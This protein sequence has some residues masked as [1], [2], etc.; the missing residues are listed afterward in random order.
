MIFN[1][2]VHHIIYHSMILYYHIRTYHHNPCTIYKINHIQFWIVLYWIVVC[3]GRIRLV[4]QLDICP[5]KRFPRTKVP[6]GSFWG[7]TV[8]RRRFTAVTEVS[9]L[10][11][12]HTVPTH[13]RLHLMRSNSDTGL[14]TDLKAN[15]KVIIIIHS[16]VA[17][18]S[19]QVL[20]HQ[21]IKPWYH[22][23]FLLV[24]TVTSGLD[25]KNGNLNPILE[26]GIPKIPKLPTTHSLDNMKTSG[27]HQLIWIKLD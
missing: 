11:H 25:S 10:A 14:Q 7:G 15:V 1:T 13:L 20:L 26:T 12:F 3:F 18:L 24:R 6:F 23:I 2:I 9:L 4:H 8:W 16:P 21:N 17:F 19:T 5:Q 27:F 22:L